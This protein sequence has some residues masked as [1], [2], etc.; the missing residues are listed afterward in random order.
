MTEVQ[1]QGDR[2]FRKMVINY[3]KIY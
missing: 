3:D 1:N 2:V